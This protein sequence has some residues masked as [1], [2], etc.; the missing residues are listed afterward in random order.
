MNFFTSKPYTILFSS[1]LILGTFI[2]ISSNN[3]ISIWIGL[4]LNLY[5]FIPLILKSYI[6]QEKEASIKYFLTQAL[7][8]V[9]LLFASILMLFSNQAIVILVVSILIKLG[10][11]PCHFWLP[12]IINSL[13]WPICLILATIQKAAPILILTQILQ[14]ISSTITIIISSIGAITGGVGGLNQTQIRAILAYSSIGHIG[15]II[16]STLSSSIITLIYFI[17]YV[18]ILTSIILSLSPTYLLLANSIYQTKPAPNSI[19]L[20][21]ISRLLSLAGLPPFFG[22]F[23]KLLI[24]IALTSIKFFILPIILVLASTLNLYF[25]LKIIVSLFFNAP[26]QNLLNI[27]KSHNISI[28][29]LSIFASFS[30]LIFL[31]LIL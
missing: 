11:A 24:L 12:S 3:W 8:S 15:W 23:P 13:S 10:A 30:S 21:S 18:I 14:P 31:I 7:A 22:F 1:T 5:S 17:T 16:A 26:Q 2:S 9:I 6:N 28:S 19:K 29:L 20:L 25:Y 27:N 4:E